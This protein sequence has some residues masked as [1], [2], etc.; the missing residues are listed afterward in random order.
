LIASAAALG[1]VPLVVAPPAH[2]KPSG[3]IEFI[4]NV[5]QRRHYIF[6]NGDAL[7]YGY[8]I[9]DNLRGGVGYPQLIDKAKNEVAPDD[10]FA[11]NFLIGQAVFALCPELIPQLRSSAAGYRPPPGDEYYGSP[12]PE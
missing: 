12:N 1:A 3:D 2:A 4:Y 9:C 10:G 11:V 5:A 7:G 6:P 8:G